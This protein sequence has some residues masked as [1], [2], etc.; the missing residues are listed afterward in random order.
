MPTQEAVL[1]ASWVRS[2]TLAWVCKHYFCPQ[3]SNIVA[4]SCVV[5]YKIRRQPS[6]LIF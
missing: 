4:K 1:K 5:N 2:N 3:Y 6:F